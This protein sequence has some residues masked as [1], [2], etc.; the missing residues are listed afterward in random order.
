MPTTVIHMREFDR[1]DPTHVRVSRP[2]AWGNP[3]RMSGNTPS[4]REPEYVAIAERRITFWTERARM[5]GGDIDRILESA[6]PDEA[7][8]GQMGIFA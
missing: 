3:Y 6:K 4:E 1:N 8:A 2:S 5:F 7:H